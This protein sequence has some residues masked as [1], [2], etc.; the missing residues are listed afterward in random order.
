MVVLATLWVCALFC[1]CD[2]QM[3]PWDAN[4]MVI[5]VLLQNGGTA[6]MAAPHGGHSGVV[7]MLLLAGAN[8]GAAANVSYC[9][10]CHTLELRA[11]CVCDPPLT[12]WNAN[13]MV[14][15]FCYRMVGRL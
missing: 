15:T 2:S 1:V 14:L 12:P 10:A 6:L 13:L 9:G 5:F 3:T 7:Q 11:V 4:L 8:R